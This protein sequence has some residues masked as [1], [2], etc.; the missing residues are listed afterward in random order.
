MTNNEI[1]KRYYE[2]FCAPLIFVNETN[3]DDNK[4]IKVYLYN[5]STQQELENFKIVYQAYL[6][7]YVQNMDRINF[8]N[9]NDTMCNL[10][11]T[12][13][14]K[15]EAKK[16]YDL[17]N[18]NIVHRTTGT[19]GMFGELLNHFHLINVLSN[20]PFLAY[21]SR[22][23]YKSNEEAKGI[24]IAV[25]NF[26]DKELEVIFSESKFVADCFNAKTKLIEDIAIHIK[27]KEINNFGQFILGNN[28]AVKSYRNTELNNIVN[29]LNKKMCTEDK[30]FI[31]SINE[32]NGKIKFVFF[33][34]FQQN[35]KRNIDDFKKNIEEI[36]TEFKY[37]IIDIGLA[38]YDVEIVFIPTFNTSMT[39]KNKMEEGL[40]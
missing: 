36:I 4:N 16:L 20:N 37:K 33:A 18:Q 7:Y 10:E 23:N 15:R 40:V 38:K 13:L 31:Q 25:C 29:K 24:D 39:I 9:I 21:L 17:T 8:L 32:I 12:D 22:K 11:L 6:P 3:L 27:A 26:H 5:F 2:E 35:T 28:D 1:L 14:L 34:V 19:N 30:S